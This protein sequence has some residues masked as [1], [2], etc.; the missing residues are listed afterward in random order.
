M[1]LRQ[2][3][4]RE[5]LMQAAAAYI[6]ETLDQAVRARGAACAALSGGETPAPA[7]RRLAAHALDWARI[8]FLLVD[9]RFVPA[10]QPSSNEAMLRDALAPALAAGAE[11]LPMYA[12]HAT[13]EQAAARADAVYADAEIDL[14]LL[15]MGGDGHT[16]SWFAQS[17]QLAAALDLANPRAVIA[18]HAPGA[19]G[20]AD[21]L[22]MTRA[23]I[24]KAKRRL[25]LLAGEN[26]RK[27]LESLAVTGAPAAALLELETEIFWAP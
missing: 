12:A 26:K 7:Y 19:A 8:K 11:V 16:A 1:N 24:A 14:A 2:F 13:P 3:A 4:T 23:A 15:G 17:P 27:T 22:T 6:A 25:L 9:E 10:A 20:S 5:A 18:V 21:R